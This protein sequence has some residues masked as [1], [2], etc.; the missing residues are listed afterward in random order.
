MI[1]Y[2]ITLKVNKDII[3]DW[4]KWQKEEHIPEIMHTGLFTEYKFFHLLEHDEEDTSTYVVQYFTGNIDNY[5]EY[6]KAHAPILREKAIA[7]WG[8]GFIGF[9]TVLETVK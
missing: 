8:D 1:V 9:R 6:I 3:A 5:N 2:N 7:R 4:L